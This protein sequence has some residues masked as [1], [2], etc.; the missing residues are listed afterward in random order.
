[1][2]EVF[3]FAR[4]CSK[5]DGEVPK[6]YMKAPFVVTRCVL[7][8][9]AGAI[10][11]IMDAATP[12]IAFYLGASAPVIVD[13]LAEGVMPRLPDPDAHGAH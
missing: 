8:F 4:G 12:M 11:M 10:P 2:V 7:P 5:L 6:R 1:V 3:A 13:K 9:F